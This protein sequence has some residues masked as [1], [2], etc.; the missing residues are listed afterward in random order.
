MIGLMVGVGLIAAG[1]VIFILGKLT[2][3]RPNVS[4]TG[5]SVAIGGSN[6][7]IVQNVNS[8]GQKESHQGGHKLTIL[9]IAVELVGIGVTLWHAFHL[10]NK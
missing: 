10:A 7:G 4:A 2:G 6:S 5:G 9:A 8:G 3:R 1:I